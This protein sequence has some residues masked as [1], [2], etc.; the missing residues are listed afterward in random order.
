VQSLVASSEPDRIDLLIA[1]ERGTDSDEVLHGLAGSIH[2][3]FAVAG[4]A[5]A[6]IGVGSL[7]GDLRDVRRSLLEAE[8]AAVSG[9]G[10]D[11]SFHRLSDVRVRGLVHLLHDDPRLQSFVERELGKLIVHDDAHGTDYLGVLRAYLRC[12]GNKTLA[13]DELGISRPALYHRIGRITEIAGIDLDSAESCTSF[14]LA[15]IALDA[16]RNLSERAARS[17]DGP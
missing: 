7:V 12:G 8:Q 9:V 4:E 3:T 1:L 14:H 15:L 10:S 11:E 16:M 13:A 17:T 2:R 5:R 6:T